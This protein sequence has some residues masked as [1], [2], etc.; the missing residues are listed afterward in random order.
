[1]TGEALLARLPAVPEALAGELAARVRDGVTAIASRW[2]DA[3]APTD[4]FA[5]Y[6]GERLVAQPDL[7]TALPRLRLDDL[8][9]A[10]WAGSGDGRGIAAFEATF[11]TDLR[12]LLDR[13]HRLPADELRQHLRVKL[14]VGTAASPPKLRDYSGFGFLQNW[15][16]VTAARSFVDVARTDQSRRYV[17]ALDEG[18]MLGLA[19]GGD[20]RDAQQREQ[21]SAAIKR[22]FA[23][24]V[25]ALAPRERTFLRH[26]SLDRLTLDQIASTYQVHRATVARTLATARARLLELTRAGVARE[27]GVDPDELHSAI[28]ALDSRLELSLSRVF[29]S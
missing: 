17:D 8:Y 18:D 6:V 27:L 19:P 12:K 15:V 13:F 4:A 29:A 3:P 20:P 5:T 9:L 24:A 22:A 11:E 10:W 25:A 23:D 14:F 2:P 7:A 16:R 21:L 1:M 28:R 26:A